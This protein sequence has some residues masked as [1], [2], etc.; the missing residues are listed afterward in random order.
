MSGSTIGNALLDRSQQLPKSSHHLNKDIEIHL[1]TIKERL[2]RGYI[3]RKAKNQEI[4]D[5]VKQQ[6]SRIEQ[7]R[8]LH[9]QGLSTQHFK[10]FQDF[11]TRE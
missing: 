6:I 9:T 10:M 1:D 3:R 7:Q 8:L 2:R 5:K 4:Q 11:L